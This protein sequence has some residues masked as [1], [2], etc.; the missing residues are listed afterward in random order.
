MISSHYDP[1]IAKLIVWGH[2]RDEALGCMLR[3][4]ENFI[5]VGPHTNTAFLRRLVESPAFRGANLDTS[6]IE[7][8]QAMLLPP[9]LPVRFTS[10]ALATAALLKQEQKDAPTD[11]S[12]PYTPW[13]STSGWRLS[14]E[15]VR[16]LRWIVSDQ[17]IDAVLTYTVSGV[18]LD[19]LGS[20]SFLS[21]LDERDGHFTL[22]AGARKIDGHVYV[23]KNFFHVFEDAEHIVLQLFDPLARLSEVDRVEGNLTAPMPGK[24]ISV[25][26]DNG[27]AVKKGTAL[28][29]ME[30][31][32][33]ELT[34]EAPV[35]GVVREVLVRADEQV[36]EG[37]QLLEFSPNSG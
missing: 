22:M 32:K 27:Q 12:D 9:V 15:C 18:S 6:L 1:M 2:S 28:L 23:E 25:F 34:I 31:M 14:G 4:L 21:V 30:A 35:D 19:A 29:V 20:T 26:V 37:L 7:R 11:A 10:V 3:A 16:P 36:A 33:M 8:N 5:V 13:A 17:R 24:I